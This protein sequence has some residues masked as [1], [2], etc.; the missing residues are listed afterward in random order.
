M[1]KHAQQ[2]DHVVCLNYRNNVFH[3]GQAFSRVVFLHFSLR[4]RTFKICQRLQCSSSNARFLFGVF[5]KFF[6]RSHSHTEGSHSHPRFMHKHVI[7]VQVRGFHPRRQR[8]PL[9]RRLPGCGIS[10]R[11]AFV[12][13]RNRDTQVRSHRQLREQ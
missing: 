4:A 3:P 2:R 9:Q 11:T 10:K 7:P 6:L 5:E 13:Y 12:S 8:Q 1:R